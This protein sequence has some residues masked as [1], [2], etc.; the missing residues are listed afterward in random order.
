MATPV[1]NRG[2]DHIAIRA[3][4]LD[5]SVTFYTEE[6][7]FRFVREWTLGGGATRVVFLDAG[8]DRLI[9][10]FDAGSTPPGGSPQ[11]LDPAHRPTDEE[12]GRLAAL[13][14]F[15]IRT[16]DVPAL[17]D[18]ALAAGA[19]PFAGPMKIMTDGADPTR[20]QAAFVRGPNDEMP[21]LV[22]EEFL[23]VGPPS[24]ARTVDADRLRTA[25]AKALAALPLVAC[26]EELPVLR[27]Y[28][29]S[30]FGRRPANPVALV[31]PDLRAVLAALEAG[32]GISALPRYLAEPALSEGRI[33]LLHRPVAP[34]LNTV[35]LAVRRGAPANPALTVVRE[36]LT[37][38]AARW[39]GL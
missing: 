9:E 7:G 1:L 4:D 17:W 36:R 14:H 5:A 10:L 37:D 23:L 39:G 28:W 33:A 16:D 34:P 15:A 13:V 22:D 19:R 21:P 32:A 12:R 20:F 25:P 24:M 18:R 29:R 35:Y 30:E 31:A 6:L 8:D 27:R 26:G 11:P 3:Y 38:A 2:L